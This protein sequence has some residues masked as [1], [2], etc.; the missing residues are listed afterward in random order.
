MGP[1]G[2]L[3][4]GSKTVEFGDQPI[5]Q[6]GRLS[7]G[8]N[9]LRRADGVLAASGTRWR[10]KAG[11]ESM[12]VRLLPIRPGRQMIG[13]GFGGRS[14]VRGIEVILAGNPHQGEEGMLRQW[15][16]SYVLWKLQASNS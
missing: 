2:R 14:K 9:R 13:V 4:G 10:R 1:G 15:R 6:G 16:P 12:P 11:G 8:Q 3:V 5:P 7:G